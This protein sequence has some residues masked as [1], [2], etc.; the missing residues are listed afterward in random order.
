MENAC[1]QFHI[2]Y[3]PEQSFLAFTSKIF[4]FVNNTHNEKYSVDHSLPVFFF[5]KANVN[6]KE[7]LF[8]TSIYKFAN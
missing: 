7:N 1:L 2:P 5:G 4:I 6:N 8:I 3:G